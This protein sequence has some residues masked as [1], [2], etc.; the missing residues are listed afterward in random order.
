ML[1]GCAAMLP[2]PNILGLPF[3]GEDAQLATMNLWCHFSHPS[4]F[5]LEIKHISNTSVA[6]MLNQKVFNAVK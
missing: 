1:L 4:T 2:T 3:W 5:E 6:R